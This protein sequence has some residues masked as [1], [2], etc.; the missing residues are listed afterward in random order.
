MQKM[1]KAKKKKKTETNDEREKI[2][3]AIEN[4]MG[5]NYGIR[6]T[7]PLD[8]IVDIKFMTFKYS[9]K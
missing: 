2:K 1:F 6:V 8:L 9:E 7:K 5:D 3:S 4:E